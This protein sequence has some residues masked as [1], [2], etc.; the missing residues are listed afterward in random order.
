MKYY[1]YKCNRCRY[2]EGWIVEYDLLKGHGCSCCHGLTTVL[3]INTI[4]DTA[5]WMCDL[6]VSE[7]DAKTHTHGSNNKVSVIC[8]DCKLEKMVKICDLY[9]NHSISCKCGDGFSYGHKYIFS[10]LTQL[11]QDFIDNYTFDWCKFYNLYKEKEVSGEYDFILEDKNI[12]IEVDGGFHRTDNNR[13][14]QTKEESIFL[15]NEKDKLALDNGYKVIRII[16]NDD[17]LNIKQNIILNKYLNILFDLSNIDWT[18]CEEFALSNRVK[19]ACKLKNNNLEMTTTEIGLILNI[20]S[21]SVRNYLKKGNKLGWCY[22]NAKEEQIRNSIKT[23]YKVTK[24]IEVFK[25]GESL[26]VFESIKCLIDKSKKILEVQLCR[27]GIREQIKNN[28]ESYKGF[29]F[30]ISS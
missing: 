27:N 14:G 26:G 28:T 13:S 1:K 6:G 23:G 20:S 9:T 29:T 25:N 8:P 5:R 22:Y 4:W 7:E 18:K 16:Y 15:D 30:N 11:K 19:E 10:L 2:N 17:N 12:I 21:D 24:K 3:G